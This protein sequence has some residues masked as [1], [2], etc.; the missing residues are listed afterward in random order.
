MP[1]KSKDEALK[2]YMSNNIIFSDIINFY[3]YNGE[4]VVKE[5][6]LKELDTT[7]VNTNDEIFEKSRDLLKE[8]VIKYDNKN[9]YILVGI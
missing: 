5:S 1:K 6:D 8:A 7:F 3:L 4:D 2:D 9:T